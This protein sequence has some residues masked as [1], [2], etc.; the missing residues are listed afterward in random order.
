MDKVKTLIIAA[1]VCVVVGLVAFLVR[2]IIHLSIFIDDIYASNKTC[3][4]CQYF[5]PVE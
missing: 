2:A 4:V 3:T 5:Q 1:I